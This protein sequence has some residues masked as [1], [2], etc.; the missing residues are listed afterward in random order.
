[1]TDLQVRTTSSPPL[2]KVNVSKSMDFHESYLFSQESS[3]RSIYREGPRREPRASLVPLSPPP[4]P[5]DL[6][7][8]VRCFVTPS[9]FAANHM[10]CLVFYGGFENHNFVFDLRTRFEQSGPKDDLHFTK[11]TKRYK[12]TEKTGSG[13]DSGLCGSGVHSEAPHRCPR[14]RAGH[15]ERLSRL[16]A[17]GCD[18]CSLRLQNSLQNTT[19]NYKKLQKTTK[20]R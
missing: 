20:P 6:R 12:T 1:M 13:S 18:F 7:T 2:G 5:A 17:Q 15:R 14:A 16:E 9:D 11:V 10:G 4:D 8:P 19:K 3:I